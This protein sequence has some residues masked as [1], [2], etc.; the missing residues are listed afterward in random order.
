MLSHSSSRLMF[1]SISAVAELMSGFSG[2]TSREYGLEGLYVYEQPVFYSLFR[3]RGRQR[4]MDTCLQLEVSQLRS[5][6][7]NVI[8][9]FIVNLR[10]ISV[11]FLL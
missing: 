8:G 10:K 1:C 3:M 9:Y 6:Y 7:P 4:V 11:G 5:F 2:V